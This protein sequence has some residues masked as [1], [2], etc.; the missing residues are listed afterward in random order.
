MPSKKR[1]ANRKKPS[2][3]P[4]A[5]KKKKKS[6][7]AL[8]KAAPKKP[9]AKKKP[10][11]K[12][13][14]KKAL[15]KKPA[16]KKAAPKKAAPK[17]VP[18]KKTARVKAVARVAKKKEPAVIVHR[19]DGAGHLDATYAKGL[20][21]QSSPRERKDEAFVDGSHVE[22]DLA[23]EM[24]ED[25]VERA[26]SGEDDAEDVANRETTEE[27]GGPFVVTTGGTEFADGTDESNPADAK[28]EPFPKT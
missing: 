21:D 22:D 19:R 28:R 15:A 14:A 17:K 6:A 13:P 1:P 16:A 4:A 20:L 3:Q 26:T 11:A 18:A 5:A 25:A 12:K 9:V 27:H 10:A 24:G 23:E 8:K 2:K 7:I